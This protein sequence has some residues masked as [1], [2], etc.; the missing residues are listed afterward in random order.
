MLRVWNCIS[1]NWNIWG[2]IKWKW[3]W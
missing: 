1:S 3:C 2:W